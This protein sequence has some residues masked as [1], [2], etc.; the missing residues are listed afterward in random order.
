[1]ETIRDQIVVAIFVDGG[2]W[3][4]S[5]QLLLMKLLMYCSGRDKGHF[6][7]RSWRESCKKKSEA[8]LVARLTGEGEFKP[9]TW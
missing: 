4:L 3:Y 6:V 9:V 8:M 2:F 5:D 1:M 7:V